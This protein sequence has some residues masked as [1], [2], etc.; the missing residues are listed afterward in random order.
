VALL[1]SKNRSKITSKTSITDAEFGVISVTFRTGM[2]GMKVR[3][4]GSAPR[5]LPLG[6]VKAYIVQLRPWLREHAGKSPSLSNGD[7]IWNGKKLTQVMASK[8]G[9]QVT[10]DKLVVAGETLE[11]REEALEK[12]LVKQAKSY[13]I[14]RLRILADVYD[15]DYSAGKVRKLS[16]R[17]GSCN[18]KR[19]VTLNYMLVTLPQEL[20][21]YVI[22]H[23]LSHLRHLNHG[24][25]FWAQVEEY[26]PGYREHRRELK[27]RAAV[28]R[29]SV[30]PN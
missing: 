21:D 15:I 16:A 5:G 12:F 25:D 3:V 27:K 29:L 19:E 28:L 8:S 7:I 11:D 23:E 30:I 1:S 2:R 4:K 26:D 24:E 6:A 13:L 9:I 10:D 20:S 14:D 18:S 17:W 22:Y